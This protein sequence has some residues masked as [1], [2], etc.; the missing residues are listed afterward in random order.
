MGTETMGRVLTEATIENLK[1]LWNVEQ[2]LLPPEKV[3][4]ITV[5]DALVDT[6]ATLLSLPTRLIRQL[7]LSPHRKRR[8]IS[9]T[10]VTE[11]TVY[12]VVRL[13]IQDRDC[14]VEVMEVPDDVPVLIG[15][16]PL[17]NLDLV[18]DLRARRLTGNPAHGGE[19]MF[20]LYW[21]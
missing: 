16:L 21:A 6:G 19:Q 2:G 15:Q 14:P 7:G 12:D 1:D 9:S 13:T 18:V 20:E 17:E 3:R 11:A 4:R 5:T 10:G 8:V